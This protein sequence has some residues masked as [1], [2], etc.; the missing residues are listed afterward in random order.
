MFFRPGTALSPGVPLTALV[1]CLSISLATTTASFWPTVTTPDQARLARTGTPL[2]EEPA[3]ALIF[4]SIFR[5]TSPER[6]IDG[7]VFRVR[8]RSWY[9]TIGMVPEVPVSDETR[10]VRLLELPGE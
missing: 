9:S 10:D 5:A 1:S 8:P 2:I 4:K 3:R 7:V 6:M